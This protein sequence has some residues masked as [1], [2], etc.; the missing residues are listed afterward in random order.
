MTLNKKAPDGPGRE[1]R[2]KLS[3]KELAKKL[4]HEAYL[5]SKEF[6]KTDP[7][8]IA[9][10]EKFKEQQQDAYQKVKEKNKAY[11][12][13]TKKASK[14]RSAK[15]KIVKQV[16]MKAL[17]VPASTVKRRN[18]RIRSGGVRGDRSGAKGKPAL[19]NLDLNYIS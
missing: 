5:R 4:R 7:R 13:E 6:R 11:R 16:K 17:L 9:M 10:K 3:R 15:T 12:D 19:N 1:T 2:R 18:Q 8:Q 14:E